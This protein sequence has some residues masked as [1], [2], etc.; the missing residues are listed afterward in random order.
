MH[1]EVRFADFRS[2]YLFSPNLVQKIK[3]V[4]LSWNF[5][6]KIISEFSGEVHFFYSQRKYPFWINFIQKVKTVA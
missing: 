6:L 1:A 5:V 4:S 2:E 3:V